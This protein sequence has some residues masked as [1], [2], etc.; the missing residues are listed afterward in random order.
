VS[1]RSS[2]AAR[3]G[4]VDRRRPNEPTNPV[5]AGSVEY[6]LTLESGAEYR[7]VIDVDRRLAGG[8]SDHLPPWTALTYNQCE[9]CPLRP[10]EGAQCPPAVDSLQILD[11]FRD[12][13][14]HQRCHARVR[15]AER[16]Y[17]KDCD[18]QTALRSILG[19]VM[20]TSGCPLLAKLRGMAA[21]HLPF[22]TVRETV[23]RTT[24]NHLLKQYFAHRNGGDA[25]L[26]LDGLRELYAELQIVN[27]A[28][29]HRI[30]V[31]ASRDASLNALL[32]LLSVTTLVSNSL[33][34]G[35]RELEALFEG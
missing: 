17:S 35:L 10:E 32:N 11:A 14:S 4:E 12:A 27:E 15:T 1:C 33:D 29:F 25:K 2:V 21:Y 23:Y 34:D 13:I 22:A 9:N 6:V 20:A 28:F 3:P 8:A 26:D 30:R 16:E 7:F 5:R 24:A 19:L 18:V 31:A